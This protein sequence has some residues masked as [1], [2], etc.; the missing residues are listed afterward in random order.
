MAE[1]QP[2]AGEMKVWTAV[3]E[4]LKN[5]EGMIKLIDDYKGCKDLAQKVSSVGIGLP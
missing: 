2:T 3:N 4:V 5:G 1:A